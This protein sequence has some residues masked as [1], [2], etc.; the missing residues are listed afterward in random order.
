MG[1]S[2]VTSP[3]P[4]PASLP[5]VRVLGTVMAFLVLRA[6][7]ASAG[8]RYL[9]RSLDELFETAFRFSNQE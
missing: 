2:D 1:L 4:T 9:E 6:V 3:N 5:V 8:N 7:L